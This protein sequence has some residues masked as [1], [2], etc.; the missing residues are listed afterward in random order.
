MQDKTPFNDKGK[1][2]GRWIVYYENNNQPFMAT[3]VNGI[4][5]GL[6]IDSTYITKKIVKEYHA[7]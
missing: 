6:L 7:H 2:H 4:E 3:Y 1:R 5:Y